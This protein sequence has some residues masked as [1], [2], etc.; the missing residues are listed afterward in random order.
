MKQLT[1]EKD[2][3]N[4]D[5]FWYHEKE[6][7]R[8]RGFLE[9]DKDK[10]PYAIVLSGFTGTGKTTAA[11]LFIKALFCENRKAGE[12]QPCGECR[13]C[14]SDPRTSTSLNNVT[15]VQR[16]QDETLANQFKKAL[17]EANQPPYGMDEDHRHYKVI[18]FDELQSIPK[19]RLQDLL[20]YPEVPT[21]TERSRV[22]FIFLTMAEEN[23]KE[24]V[25]KPL[26]DRARYFRFRKLSET[27]I[28][29]YLK[30]QEPYAPDES[31]EII[32]H[33]ADGSI[34]GALSA[35][36][37]CLEVDSHLSVENVAETLY[38]VSAATRLRI[39]KMIQEYDYKGLHTFWQ[40]NIY[41]FDEQKLVIQMMRDLDLAMV[42]RPTADQLRA[43]S[44]LYH[45][46][47]TSRKVRVLDTLKLLIGL[48]LITDETLLTRS[49]LEQSGYERISTPQPT[50]A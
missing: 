37:D 49:P 26:R 8:L 47:C 2:P 25:F 33:Y 22:I 11:R 38:Y 29:Q 28:F 27:E 9:N 3:Q 32:A 30:K 20:F 43:H 17:Q 4:W 21:I 10:M 42:K 19:D 39:W 6:V 44:L 18:V 14:K 48:D 50:Y 45:H 1:I 46:V 41:H 24:G 12:S 36:D 15:W 34:R 13:T 40:Q 7:K 31:L 23:I 16:G 35:L 5:E